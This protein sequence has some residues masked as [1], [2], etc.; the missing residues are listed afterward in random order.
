MLSNHVHEQ[1][2]LIEVFVEV[3]DVVRV[4][5]GKF[6][7]DVRGIGRNQRVEIQGRIKGVRRTMGH[8]QDSVF[9][10]MQQLLKH[11]RVLMGQQHAAFRATPRCG[12]PTDANDGPGGGGWHGSEEIGW[13]VGCQPLGRRLVG[14]EE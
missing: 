10:G 12:R 6:P 4:V 14:E 5:D 2:N 13:W 11:K 1:F 7:H 8:V 9:R 3:F